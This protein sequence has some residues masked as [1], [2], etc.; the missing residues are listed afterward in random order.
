MV[1]QATKAVANLAV[2]PEHK[3]KIFDRNGLQPLFRLATSASIEAR[4]EAVAAIANLAVDNT[5][6]VE[7]ARMG[8]IEV[9]TDILRENTNTELQ[10]QACR[11]IRNLSVS[12][13]NARELV[14]NDVENVVH[15]VLDNS[16]DPTCQ[17]QLEKCLLNLQKYS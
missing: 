15:K 4:I 9:V 3:T 2:K 13:R 14:A 8:G 16:S 10:R 17:R 7:I 6:E 12:V 11:A 1:R 5:L